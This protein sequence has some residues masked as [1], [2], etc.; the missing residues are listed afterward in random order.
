MYVKLMFIMY[1]R[2]AEEEYVIIFETCPN[3]IMRIQMLLL[4]VFLWLYKV[5]TLPQ[6]ERPPVGANRPRLTVEM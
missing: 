6:L 4:C 2:I 5:S 1:C 3:K